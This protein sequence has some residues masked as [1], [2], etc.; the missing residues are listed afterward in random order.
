MAGCSW[1]G[2]AGAASHPSWLLSKLRQVPNEHHSARKVFYFP[3][4]QRSLLFPV[5]KS[6][7]EVG[8]Q[9]RLTSSPTGIGKNTVVRGE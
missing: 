1:G 8:R 3:S 5:Q 2:G 6:R 9:P 7:G 4:G